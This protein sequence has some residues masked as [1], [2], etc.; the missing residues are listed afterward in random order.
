MTYYWKVGALTSLS[1]Q[2]SSSS[3]WVEFLVVPSSV[4]RDT[5]IFLSFRLLSYETLRWNHPKWFKILNK[6]HRYNWSICTELE[7]QKRCS[8]IERFF[9]FKNYISIKL[10]SQRGYVP[11]W[12]DRPTPRDRWKEERSTSRGRKAPA[13]RKLLVSSSVQTDQLTVS[14][15]FHTRPLG[16]G[17]SCD[18]IAFRGLTAFS[19]TNW[20]INETNDQT[21][22]PGDGALRC[23]SLTAGMT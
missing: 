19:T 23:S 18:T 6:V 13:F 3:V 15:T 1:N 17:W 21:W 20:R 2:D 11:Q 8:N 10:V 16:R 7:A 4:M 14:A 22:P 9:L 5:H 12:R